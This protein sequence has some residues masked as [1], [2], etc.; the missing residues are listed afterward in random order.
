MSIRRI[1]FQKKKYVKQ[2]KGDRRKTIDKKERQRKNDI[3]IYKSK[4]KKVK[5]RVKF[6]RN[7]GDP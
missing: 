1:Y 6:S 3:L 2:E 4:T 7:L 5:G